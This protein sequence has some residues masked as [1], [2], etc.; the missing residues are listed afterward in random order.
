MNVLYSNMFILTSCARI[1]FRCVWMYNHI[2]ILYMDPNSENNGK[3][4]FIDIDGTLVHNKEEENLE[5]LLHLDDVNTDSIEQ[6]LPN[7]KHFW[8][9]ISDNDVIIITTARSE[10]YRC[11]TEKLFTKYNLRYDKLIM[12]LRTGPRVLINDTPDLTFQK[13]VAIN[14][15]RDQGF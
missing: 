7:V 12:D 5:E 9:N 14:V 15:K 8:N 13:A 6:L 4:Y 1:I 3:T 10:K 2:I 11:L